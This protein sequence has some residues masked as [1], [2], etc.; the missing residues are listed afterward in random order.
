MTP[1]QALNN[2]YTASRRAQLTA[3]E[4]DIIKQSADVVLEAIKPK[5]DGKVVELKDETA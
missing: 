2:L 5:G 3:E 4:H 1:I